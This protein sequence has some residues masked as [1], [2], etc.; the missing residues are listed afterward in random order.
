MIVRYSRT[1]GRV[2]PPDNEGLQIE[3]DGSF[4]MWRSIAPAVGRFAGKLDAGELTKIKS[5]AKEAAAAGDFSKPPSPDGALDQIDVEGGH[6]SL[7]SNDYAE[8]PWSALLEHLRKLL[9]DLISKPRAAV[10][11]EVASDGR[12]ARLVHLGEKPLAVDLSGLSVR[13]VLWGR[14]Y[15]KLG[16]WN[17]S[18]KVAGSAPVEAGKSWNVALPLDHDFK[19][20]KDKVLHV[21]ATFAVTEDGQRAEVTAQ[22]IPPIPE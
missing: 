3:D 1:G 19:T 22:H 17:S 4:S 16:D 13:A 11:L 6:A 20:G 8:G 7:G 14:G 2:P 15:R 12:N 21:Y 10:G 9:N 5:E 18:S